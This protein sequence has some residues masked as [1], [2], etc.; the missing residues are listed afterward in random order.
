MPEV[1]AIKQSLPQNS[2]IELSQIT[3]RTMVLLRVR[4]NAALAATASLSLPGQALHWSGEYPAIHWLGPD[5]WL[6]TSDIEGA[7]NIIAR[8]DKAISNQLYAAIDMSS[9]YACF[10]LSGPAARTVLA[11]G[12]GIDL[13]TSAFKPGHCTRTHFA[14]VSL[15]IVAVQESRF[16][17]YIDRSLASYLRNWLVD[18]AQDPI[19]YD[20]NSDRN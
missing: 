20:M 13:D 7:A 14:N 19:T 4:E 11:M 3:G 9:S 15:F 6:F 16:N 5:Q 1:L 10:S 17:L 12:C 2:G 8:I 18:S